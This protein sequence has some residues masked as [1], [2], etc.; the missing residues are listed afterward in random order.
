MDYERN[1]NGEYLV[2]IVMPAYNASRTIADS[3]QS[4]ID[5]TYQN[6]ELLIVDD[7]STDNTID[8]CRE[9]ISKDSRIKYIELPEKGGAAGA[10]N[11]AIDEAQGRFVAFLDSDD[12]WL[13]SK[14][15]IQISKMLSHQSSFSYTAYWKMTSTGERS[16]RYISVPST[17]N[18]SK[19]LDGCVIGCLTVV[20]DISVFGKQYIDEIFMRNDLVYWLK[21]TKK[22]GHEDYS[23]WL[24][25]TKILERKKNNNKSV[26][27][28]LGINQPLAVY[29]VA[30][31]S[32]S[33]NK[34]RA[35]YYQWI[36]YRK[37]E[38]LGLFVSCKHFFLYALRGIYKYMIW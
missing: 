38:K 20:I 8:I 9:F 30:K 1:T 29:R 35:A 7:I 23:L 27:P 36:V 24:K 14:L 17:T 18:Y 12:L 25:L 6:W 26:L 11:R 19:L 28:I 33:H 3:I 37:V 21:L 10:R 2:S 15:S 5:Q 4:V 13:P 32:L 16:K 22:L 34:F 31:G